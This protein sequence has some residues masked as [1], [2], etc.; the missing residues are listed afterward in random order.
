MRKNTVGIMLLVASAFTGTLAFRLSTPAIAFYTRDILNTSMAYISVISASFIMTRSFS[1]VFG[2]LLLEKKK[3]IVYLGAIAMIGNALIVNLYPYTSTWVHVM[4]IK[5]MNG[6]LN[7]IS[8]PIAQF[9]IAVSSP[10]EIR[11]RVTAVYFIF[12]NFAALLGNYTYAI[13]QDYGLRWQMFF[14]SFFFLLTAFCMLTSYHILYKKII[15]KKEE[16]PKKG[17]IQIDAKKI[18]ILSSLISFL[19]AF[20]FGEITYVYVAETLALDKGTAATMI[21]LTGFMATLLAYIPSKYADLGKEKK[22]IIGISVM[23]G[24]SPLLAAVKNP[25][26]VFMGILMA[27]FA[28]QTFRPISRGILASVRRASVAIGG[29]NAV[30]NIST[31]IGQLVFGF[32]YSSL[33][34]VVIAGIILNASLLI[35]APVLL[36]LLRIAIKIK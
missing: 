9:V 31:T 8:W 13:T 36:L 34:E 20:T 3:S 24:V 27:I 23:A 6:L 7:G 28:S 15:P 18:I 16:E 21:G 19:A 30:G 26:T 29:V 10:K 2:G 22:I 33:G 25:F 35:F 5:V 4:E 14:A 12:G 17:K 11:S 1:A 32:A